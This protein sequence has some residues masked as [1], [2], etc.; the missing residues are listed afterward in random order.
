VIH[1]C[2]KCGHEDEIRL[3]DVPLT[4][5]EDELLGPEEPAGAMAP[6]DPM[7]S[8]WRHIYAVSM[9]SAAKVVG[10]PRA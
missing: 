6:A 5:L 3:A 7:E 4:D 9:D 2:S 8:F 10:P 1:K